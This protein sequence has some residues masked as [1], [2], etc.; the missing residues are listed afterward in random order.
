MA[1]SPGCYSSF[2]PCKKT[3]GV[4][5]LK[6]G[7]VIILLFSVWVFVDAIVTA[8][9]LT[10]CRDLFCLMHFTQYNTVQKFGVGKI[11][12]CF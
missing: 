7:K 5:A 10:F 9:L 12:Y 2:F 6:E 3:N 4:C 1:S 11:L 8:A